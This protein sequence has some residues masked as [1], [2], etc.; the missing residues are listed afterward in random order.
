MR[1][2]NKILL[3]ICGIV[4]GL[5]LVTFFVIRYWIQEETEARFAEE[6]QGNYSTVSEIT[7]LRAKQNI[8]T[9]QVVAE[10][11]RLKAVVEL[12]DRGTMLHLSRELNNEIQSDL[13]IIT[14]PVGRP[15]ASLLHGRETPIDLSDFPSIADALE[16]EPQSHVWCNAGE[17]YTIASVP[18]FAGSEMVGTLTIGFSI[19]KDDIRLIS[20]MTGNQILLVYDSTA[21]LSTVERGGEL[22]ASLL[23]G[24]W[25]AGE[26]TERV[27]PIRTAGNSFLAIFFPL[28]L[29]SH[30]SSSGTGYLMF[31][32]VQQE[33][34]TVL[35]PVLQAFAAF[36]VI[37][38]LI[39]AAAGYFISRSITRPIDA[40]VLGTTE[41]S[42]GNYDYRLGVTVGGEL[43]FLAAKFGEMSASLKE[44]VAQ[45][46][47]RNIDLEQ[48]LRT[49]MENQGRFQAILDTT[50]ALIYVKDLEGKY[51]LINRKFETVF[52]LMSGDVIGKTDHELFPAEIAAVLTAHD[53]DVVRNNIVFEGEQRLRQDKTAPSYFSHKFALFDGGGAVYALCGVLTDITERKVLEGQLRQAQKLESLGTL[54]GGI[55]HDFNNIL[56]IILGHTSVLERKTDDRAKFQ[57]SIESINRSVDRGTGL[58]RQL[59]TF[60][61]KTDVLFEPV[62]ANN[63][64]KELIQMLEATFPKN[65]TFSADLDPKL[66]LITADANQLHQALLNLSVNARDVMPDGGKL[67]FI[68]KAVAGKLVAERFPDAKRSAYVCISVSDTG[69]GM[70]EQTMRRIFEPFFTTKGVGKGT[71]L[72]LAVVYG[73]M[74]SHEGFADFESEIGEGTTFHLYFPTVPQ[75]VKTRKP[76]GSNGHASDGGTETILLIEDE[77]MLSDL[78]KNVLQ[79]KGY[80]VFTAADGVE[81]LEF[82]LENKDSLDL[83][84]TDLGLPRL[85]NWEL[86]KHIRSAL[87]DTPILVASGYF[88]PDAKAEMDK[89]GADMFVQK[90]YRLDDVLSKIREMLDG[91]VKAK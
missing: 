40:L 61:R 25:S 52:R 72:G 82:L 39:A 6:L 23:D 38:L 50:P 57:E 29:E 64:V 27:F 28:K 68:T 10:S 15:L 8:R 90:P 75:E 62:K 9:C 78:V 49:I 16:L 46:H 45:L 59:L 56:A 35:Y 3:S 70:D 21:V 22:P 20:S 91:V 18:I 2:H 44:K 89:A 54:A 36:S 51:L 7:R 31:K 53:D 65:I 26:S 37:V 14:D 73:V 19:R 74:E 66:P 41:V 69:S 24:L 48:A 76:A 85:G 88:D 80:E 47:D 71:G 79:L 42:R 5:Q 58:V 60:A 11:P 55:A 67:T 32:S 13:V 17:A 4:L 84:I 77:K 86:V 1:F 87:P 34:E 12:S 43:G 30:R 33:V 83:V 81:A 63:V